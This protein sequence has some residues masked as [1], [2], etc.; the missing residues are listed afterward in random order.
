MSIWGKIIGGAAGFALGGPLGALLGAIAG[1]TFVDTGKRSANTHSRKQVAF[2]AGVI[3]LAA[4]MAKADGVVTD[5]ETEA[6]RKVFHP[7]LGD[8][9]RQAEI[10]RVFDVAK[11]DSQG[12]EP[13][14]QQLAEMFSNNPVVLEELLNC[15]FLIARADNV[16]HSKENEYLESVAR[17]FGL[18]ETTFRT[19]SRRA[20]S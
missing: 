20:R 1:H 19:D 16:Y 3:V 14:A 17:I 10:M 9:V 2:T 12:F 5:E 15:L 11:K 18:D 8:E 6:F 7:I 4:K 13:Y